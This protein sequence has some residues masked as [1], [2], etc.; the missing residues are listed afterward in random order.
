MT[1]FK[2]GDMVC[3]KPEDYK[4]AK[5]LGATKLTGIEVLD[6]SGYYEVLLD[7]DNEWWGSPWVVLESEFVNTK[8]DV[9]K[10]I[11]QTLADNNLTPYDLINSYTIEEPIRGRKFR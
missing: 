10:Q 11:L 1:K 8:E 2:I 5:M 3:F 6:T 4:N 7:T 9:I